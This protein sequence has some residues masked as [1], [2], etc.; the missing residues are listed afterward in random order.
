MKLAEAGVTKRKLFPWGLKILTKIL[1]PLQYYLNKIKYERK[2]LGFSRHLSPY[3]FIFPQT[4]CGLIYIKKSSQ[5]SF[6]I[7]KLQPLDNNWL[8]AG[9]SI[10]HVSPDK[11]VPK[12]NIIIT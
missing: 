9:K 6:S 3:H 7:F 12:S 10:L 11:K 1:I 4:S 2:T 5:R 8:F